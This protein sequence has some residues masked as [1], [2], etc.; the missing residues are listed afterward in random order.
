MHKIRKWHWNKS[1]EMKVLHQSQVFSKPKKVFNL[2]AAKITVFT[3]KVTLN[4]GSFSSISFTEYSMH[5]D[6]INSVYLKFLRECNAFCRIA[7]S[8]TVQKLEHQSDVLKNEKFYFMFFNIFTIYLKW[9]T[10]W[11]FK[12][13]EFLFNFNVCFK[14]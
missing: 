2:H 5:F 14:Y 4:W 3:S 9:C 7:I 13:Q 1:L 10:Q 12:Q 6:V 8:S 11:P